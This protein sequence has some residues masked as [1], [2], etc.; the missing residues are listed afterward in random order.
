[1]PLDISLVRRAQGEFNNRIAQPRGVQALPGRPGP[2]TVRNG[3]QWLVAALAL[4]SAMAIGR[5]PP[6]GVRAPAGDPAP[7]PGARAQ[8][9]IDHQAVPMLGDAPTAPVVALEHI[10][11]GATLGC[12]ASPRHC[13]QTLAASLLTFG[14]LTAST[15][16]GGALGY[17]FGRSN[18]PAARSDASRA[19]SPSLPQSLYAL[20]PDEQRMQLLQ[21]VR[22]CGTDTAACTAPAIHDLLEALPADVR[23]R[24]MATLGVAQHRGTH[25]HGGWPSGADAA[26]LAPALDWM[27]WAAALLGSAVTPAQA[28]FQLDLEQ[29]A[30]ATLT[31]Q[32]GLTTG[33]EREAAANRA[34]FATLRELLQ[35]DGHALQQLP[36]NGTTH[37]S[38]GF[39]TDYTGCNLMLEFNGAGAP[40]HTLMVLAHGDMTGAREGSS[41]ASDNG[42]GLA[43]LLALARRLDALTLPPGVRV[44]LLVTDLEER[45][46]LGAKS[47]AADCVQHANCPDVALNLDMIGRGDGMTLSGSDRHHLYMDGDSRALQ[48]A[49]ATVAPAEAH[50]RQ[51]LE[52]A[53]ANVGLR[54]HASP[55]WVMQSDHIAFQRKGIPALGM[56]LADASDLPLERDMQQARAQLLLASDGVDWSRFEEYLDGT[57][58]AAQVPAMDR[59]LDEVEQARRTY[60]ALPLSPG[61][62]RIHNGQDQLHQVHP[63]RAMAALAVLEAAIDAWLQQPT[64]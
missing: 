46:M 52:R 19:S 9:G 53:A 43:A 36:F 12:I 64:A 3:Q 59:A 47:Y 33:A 63:E 61:M 7:L 62:T 15:L 56:N 26:A 10:A 21:I 5:M 39:G 23:H 17:A 18:A 13:P 28:A 55:D 57:L 2:L 49:T 6:R 34:R 22:D 29:I 30:Q 16:G 38:F 20:L 51:L 58:E 14:A 24:I 35:R 41:G 27:E 4:S 8:G 32:A 42:T 45:G 37:D 50:L 60:F 54:V 44:Q 25:R 1:M 11:N 40:A 48:P 31:G